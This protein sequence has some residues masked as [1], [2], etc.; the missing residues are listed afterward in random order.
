MT[1]YSGEFR[2]VIFLHL[3]VLGE[4]AEHLKKEGKPFAAVLWAGLWLLKKGW[5][6]FQHVVY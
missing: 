5:G 6:N 3:P 4:N 2:F 1:S